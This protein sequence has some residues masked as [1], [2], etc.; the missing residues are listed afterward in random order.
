MK[1]IKKVICSLLTI[2]LFNTQC[3]FAYTP[4]TGFWAERQKYS[5]KLKK[6]NHS[7][8]LLA[9][10]P[11][12]ASID[13]LQNLPSVGSLASEQPISNISDRIQQKLNKSVSP[14]ILSL[15][16]AVP[17]DCGNVR[18]IVLG[19]QTL[20]GKEPSGTVFHI[21]DV[22]MNHEAQ[23]NIGRSVEQLIDQGTIG[24]VALEGASYPIRLK[25]IR[26]YPDKPILKEITDLLLKENKISGPV[27][28]GITH[29]KTNIPPFVGIDDPDHYQAN[30]KAYQQAVPLQN[31]Y[32]KSLLKYTESVK[33]EKVSVFNKSLLAYDNLIY[34]YKQGQIQLGDYLR[35]MSKHIKNTPQNIQIFLKAYDMEQ[36]LAFNQVEKERAV[37]IKE[38]VKKLNQKDMQQLL[39]NSMAYRASQI[40]HSGFYKYLK[41]ICESSGVYLSRFPHMKTYLQY[42]IISD[43]IH[44]ETLFKEMNQ[45]EEQGY[46]QLTKTTKE[47][48]LVSD[49]EYL[50]LLGKLLAF[51][52]T[53]VEWEKYQN[54][55]NRQQKFYLGETKSFVNFYLEAQ[56][57]DKAI[58]ENLIKNMKD[59]HAPIAVLV[60]GGFHSTG[61]SQKLQEANIT[62]I[63]FV[64]KITQIE[65]DNGTHYLSVFS[66][67]KTPLEQMFQGEKLF[68]AK[69]P[70]PAS[71]IWSL[72]F[73]G[74]AKGFDSGKV[75]KDQLFQWFQAVTNSLLIQVK[76]VGRVIQITFQSK[77]STESFDVD[78]EIGPN[79]TAALRNTK[80]HSPLS[81]FLRKI[82][83]K[84]KNIL[85]N[86]I[87][88]IAWPFMI[89]EEMLHL[90]SVPIINIGIGIHSLATKQTFRPLKIDWKNT[91]KSLLKLDP[92]VLIF[93]QTET[94]APMALAS[95]SAPMA[96]AVLFPTLLISYKFTG[97]FPVIFAITSFVMI[98]AHIG[99]RRTPGSDL[100]IAGQYIKSLLV[101]KDESVVPQAIP[102][103]SPALAVSLHNPINLLEFQRKRKWLNFPD[104]FFNYTIE[105]A[106]LI[107]RYWEVQPNKSLDREILERSNATR[108]GEEMTIAEDAAIGLIEVLSTIIKNESEPQT[109]INNRYVL[110]RT[111]SEGKKYAI[112][113]MRYVL[114]KE[115]AA[116]KSEAFAYVV[117]LRNFW[118]DNPTYTLEDAIQ[119]M[120]DPDETL[121]ERGKAIGRELV[122]KMNGQI[123][124]DIANGAV[125]E[126]DSLSVFDAISDIIDKKVAPLAKPAR[127]APSA[128]IL[129]LPQ[130]DHASP[131]MQVAD[132]DINI[133]IRRW[134]DYNTDFFSFVIMRVNLILDFWEE[135]IQMPFGEDVLKTKNWRQMGL[136]GAD[137]GAEELVK[138]FVSRYHND[139]NKEI[140]RKI[141]LFIK[142]NEPKL[143]QDAYSYVS[144]LIELWRKDPNKTLE[145]T[146]D[147]MSQQPTSR[148]L[149][150]DLIGRELIKYMHR[151][152][153]TELA[154]NESEE[155]IN[156][157]ILDVISSIIS[158]T[159]VTFATPVQK[160]P[161]TPTQS[162]VETKKELVKSVAAPVESSSLDLT[163]YNDAIFERVIELLGVWEEDPAFDLKDVISLNMSMGGFDASGVA[164]IQKLLQKLHD[165]SKEKTPGSMLTLLI[166]NK[167]VSLKSPLPLFIKWL[168]G[169]LEIAFER[170]SYFV[171]QIF[172]ENKLSMEWSEA[173]SNAMKTVDRG[174]DYTDPSIVSNIGARVDKNL[175][176]LRHTDSINS[177]GQRIQLIQTG[178]PYLKNPQGTK[179][180]KTSVKQNFGPKRTFTFANIQWMLWGVVGKIGLRAQVLA[181]AIKDNKNPASVVFPEIYQETE[182]EEVL[183]DAMLAHLTEDNSSKGG[184]VVV[185]NQGTKALWTQ[186]IASLKMKNPNISHVPV[187]VIQG[188]VV[189]DNK[190]V[191]ALKLHEIFATERL[192]DKNYD[193]FNFLL[194]AGYVFD[195]KKLSLNSPLRQSIIILFNGPLA[196][197]IESMH[198]E[199]LNVIER[200]IF[201]AA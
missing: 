121:T 139:S 147:E 40:S 198:L 195:M 120:A 140:I 21:Q 58:T 62:T 41:G 90:L 167:P 22:H 130:S 54:K 81:E 191:D 118:R 138:S 128:S 79:S 193:F 46:K 25:E 201:T 19:N 60:T 162:P 95:V 105:N 12:Q 43:K 107:F 126:K 135:N 169:I 77:E 184:L 15:V 92:E 182:R 70:A 125:G 194:P 134:A 148:I 163:E 16:K 80:L 11:G 59:M 10:A 55:P 69:I 185:V 181:K 97:I 29:E 23:Q 109:L 110:L 190:H 51:S 34:S 49:S 57:R 177:I 28:A 151:Q 116:I 88:T 199:R 17:Q 192:F 68:L 154:S 179:T 155:V 63:T 197:A 89:M 175:G 52:L 24:L 112:G 113:K 127:K 66:Q 100:Y 32:Q 111:D 124:F 141:L 103:L 146:I 133:D 161:R 117:E 131:H 145:Q 84:K 157:V 50:Y 48:D 53:P 2:I 183:L 189:A 200:A 160:D 7:P 82:L 170:I 188:D 149:E 173:V 165:E 13:L 83:P 104:S 75:G 74:V 42:V 159:V 73:L 178:M 85:E 67:E 174:S 180:F 137:E 172:A 71:S 39:Q 196:V 99:V 142:R 61:I 78:V 4:E 8:L 158:K 86:T 26:Q 187:N 156:R 119:R 114:E 168:Q 14:D 37:L 108:Y 122:K 47:K 65:T 45:M 176:S 129:S 6:K 18:D 27:H 44:A 94:E 76:R 150:A 3:V 123:E 115:E 171:L 186:A 106:L 136:H 1:S 143:K 33:Q 56:A 35:N 9:K 5:E 153:K 20:S 164:K 72:A 87:L 98:V 152:M 36:N 166:S 64:P 132:G 144:D 101:P 31:N 96:W 30:V 93:N 102:S 38:L 91:G